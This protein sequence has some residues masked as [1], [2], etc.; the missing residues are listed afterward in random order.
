MNSDKRC[1]IGSLATAL[2]FL[3]VI[4][5]LNWPSMNPLLF[6]VMNPREALCQKYKAQL[7]C[8]QVYPWRRNAAARNF[9]DGYSGIFHGGIGTQGKKMASSP[10]CFLD[11]GE[12]STYEFQTLE[13]DL[14]STN[15]ILVDGEIPDLTSTKGF[16]FGPKQI[17]SWLDSTFTERFGVRTSK[18]GIIVIF[19]QRPKVELYYQRKNFKGYLI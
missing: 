6:C 4:A 15:F 10:P 12:D 19:S 16:D 13:L 3:L 1:T 18:N 5:L 7:D 2:L 9:F 14:S 11:I 17:F 8:M